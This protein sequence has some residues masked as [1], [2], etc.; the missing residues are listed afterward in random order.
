MPLAFLETANQDLLVLLD[1][2]V[3][4][5]FQDRKVP[6]ELPDS[7]HRV[8]PVHRDRVAFLALLVPLVCRDHQ[9]L[10]EFRDKWVLRDLVVRLALREEQDLLDQRVH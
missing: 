10:L 4:K 7:D 9:D 2:R 5:V 1:I 3:R 6:P 8:P